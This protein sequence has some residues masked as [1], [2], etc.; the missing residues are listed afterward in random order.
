MRLVLRRARLAKG[1]LVAAGAAALVAT[2]MLTG[3]ADYSQQAIAAG[4]RS[5]L[6]AAP[7]EER[8]LLV[9][10]SAGQREADFAARDA[11]VHAR[12][13]SGLGGVPV[14]V[15]G[16]RYGTGRQLTG[17]LGPATPAGSGAVFAAMVALPN[18]PEHA[19][20]TAG[21]WPRAGGSPLQVALPEAVASRLAV[22]VGERIP[23][24][25]RGTK[26]ASEV[27]VVGLWHPRDVREAYWRLAPEIGDGGNP[28]STTSYGPFVLAGDDFAATFTGTTSAG[29]LVEPAL[30][31]A[32]AAQLAEVKRAA[33]VVVDDLP[34]A[35]GFGS[36]GQVVTAVDRLIDRLTRA[37]LVGRSALLTPMLLIV[38]LGGYTLVLVAA[39]LSEDRRAQTALLRARGAAR[40]Q[41]AGLAAREAT[42]VVLPGVILAPLLASQAMRYADHSGALSGLHLESGLTLSTWLVAG[43]AAAGCLLAML[44][45]ALRRGGT[46]VADLAARSRPDRW[47][48]AQRASVDIAL[49]ALAVLAWSQL[50]GYSSPLA[51]AGGGLGVDP[52]LAAAPTLGVLAGAVIALRLLPPATRFAERFVTRKPWTAIVLG[53]WQAG[54]RPHAGPVLLLA[55]AVGSSTLAWSLVTT[56]EGSLTDQANHQVGADLRLVERN[57]AAPPDRAAQLA[58]VPGVRTALPGW[59]DEVRLGPDNVPAT[60]V[61]IDAAAA[62]NVMRLSDELVDGS[63]HAMFDRLASARLAAP[64]TD[65]PTDARRISGMISTPVVAATALR[66]V[67]TVAILTTADGLTYRLPLASTASTGNA[68]RFAVDLPDAGG[69]A[70]RLAGFAVDAGQANGTEYQLQVTQ[71]RLS[72]ADGS[73]ELLDLGNGLWSLVD[74]TSRRPPEVTV[75]GDTLTARYPGV[76]VDTFQHVP[77]VRFAVVPAAG[78]GPVPAVATPEALRALSLS[79]GDTTPFSLSGASITIKVVGSVTAVPATDGTAAAV[80]LDLPSAVTWMVRDSGTVRAQPEWWLAT[81]PAR[82]DGTVDA[83]ARLSGVTVLDRLAVAQAAGRDPYW[84]GARTGLLAAAL[85]AVLLALV[86]LGVDGWATARRR[87]GELAVLH[88]LGATPRLLARAL[89]AEQTFL[90]GIGVAVGL[91]VGAAVSATV[92]PL[93]ILTP[94]AGRPVPAPVFDLP[95]PAI[96]ATAAGLLLVTLAF[97]VVVASTIRQRVAA[98]QLRIGGDQ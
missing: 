42:L 91:I 98:A 48:V 34:D 10:G 73:T 25:D 5:V 2:A 85:G 61:A 54:R 18:L 70:L 49:V 8:S 84:L 87:I 95:W 26:Q 67:T 76:V 44:G 63:P 93:V 1:L 96:G 37:N 13:A 80:L 58:A 79:V 82:H 47:A 62:G 51:G 3:L 69:R 35:V 12:F 16:A 60:V 30:G 89:L 94:S 65:L 78:Q 53:M 17:D 29:W 57:G 27:V 21:D 15:A 36:S 28:G 43:A 20:L 38:V 39:L 56:W 97:S 92:A 90:A 11:A 64:G 9:N 7:A 22:T 68:A 83:A 19:E 46:Y 41:L 23:L 4:Q 88:T 55:L 40:G 86:G 6:R 50:R 45:P 52:L 14:T 31:A 24:T 74:G 77:Y 81:D 32:D 66:T 33:A 59:R 71:L 72:Q 75:A